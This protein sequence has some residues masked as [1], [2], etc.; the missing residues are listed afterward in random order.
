MGYEAPNGE[1]NPN[2][3]SLYFITKEN[4]PHPKAVITPVNISNG[5]AWNRANDKFYYIDTPTNQVKEY[6]Y[7][8]DSGSIRNPRVVFDVKDFA[9]NITGHPDGMTIDTDDN[10]WIALYDGGAVIKVDPRTKKLLQIVPIPAQYTTSACWGGPHYDILFVTTSRYMLNDEDRKRQS[11]AGSVF[12]VKGL[13]ARG[14]PL[15]R[16]KIFSLESHRDAGHRI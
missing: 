10:L 6:D 9:E 8:N 5:L 14:L 1:L 15:F 4:L 2:R 7:D 13:N 3:G 16:T 12:A 11:A